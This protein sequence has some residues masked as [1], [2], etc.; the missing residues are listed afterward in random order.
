MAPTIT[1]LN[2]LTLA[3]HD[4]SRSVSFY[5]EVLGCKL[6]AVWNEGAYLEAGELWLC[7]SYD[8]A[9]RTSPHPDYTHIAFTVAE[10]EFPALAARLTASC[11]TWKDNRSEGA[12]FYF[13]DPDGHKLEIHVGSLESRL[14]YY[15]AHPEKNVRIL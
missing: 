5:T 2:H 3:V 13:L 6:R 12:S 10:D 8:P 9:A 4:V 14:D 7:L 1:G 11:P 15:R